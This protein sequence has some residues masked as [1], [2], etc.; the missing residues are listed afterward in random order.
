MNFRTLDIAHF[1]DHKGDGTLGVYPVLPTHSLSSYKTPNM[2]T[3]AIRVVMVTP[4]AVS[5]TITEI[6][7]FTEVGAGT[8]TCSWSLCLFDQTTNTVGTVLTSGTKTTASYAWNS[9]TGL[10]VDVVAGQSIALVLANGA[11]TPASNY[12][13]PHMTYGFKTNPSAKT[14]YS[15][16]SGAT[17]AEEV[18][19]YPTVCY[20]TSTSSI[21]GNNINCNFFGSPGGSFPV[22]HNNGVARR[23]GVA[24]LPKDPE[25]VVTVKGLFE[26]TG[27]YASRGVLYAEIY[28]GTPSS[29]VL[30][31]RSINT[32]K[33]DITYSSSNSRYLLASFEFD[34]NAIITPNVWTAYVFGATG[35]D[36]SNGWILRPPTD[37]GLAV[38]RDVYLDMVAGQPLPFGDGAYPIECDQASQIIFTSSAAN[39][40]FPMV[41]AWVRPASSLSIPI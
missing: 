28:Q 12:F 5:A 6:R 4:V 19:G 1:A 30:I 11:G 33:R 21:F 23:A 35:G 24:R 32:W 13:A 36:G 39:K 10:T 18:G 41:E 26:G 27:V 29:P 34:S 2:S 37:R 38:T 22:L 31:A 20:T 7:F 15:T 8:Q 17:W 3:A 16:D 40:S 25:R 9:I 14:L